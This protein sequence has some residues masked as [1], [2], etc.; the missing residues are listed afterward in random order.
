M[1]T[2]SLNGT[3]TLYYAESGKYEIPHI[4][5]TVPGNVE[6]DLSKNGLITDDLFMSKNFLGD[7]RKI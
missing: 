6:L 2:K 3:W 7:V 4:P 5:A 1:K